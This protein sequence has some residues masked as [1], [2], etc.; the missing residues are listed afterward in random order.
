VVAVQTARSAA[1]AAAN[2]LPD[3]RVGLD[4][5]GPQIGAKAVSVIGLAQS[6][7]ELV[8]P[9]RGVC[10]IESVDTDLVRAAHDG[11]TG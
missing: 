10:N 8:Q 2:D 4:E 1:A 6:A 9:E 5:A 11:L 3:R 7:G